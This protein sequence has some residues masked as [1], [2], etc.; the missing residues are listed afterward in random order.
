MMA[1]ENNVD[2][3]LKDLEQG[4]FSFRMVDCINQHIQRQQTEL[5][6]LQLFKTRA[7]IDL[8][9]YE[10][11]TARLERDLRIVNGAI[12][13]L[14]KTNALLEE[15]IAAAKYGVAKF[16]EVAVPKIQQAAVDAQPYAIEAFKY[17]RTAVLKA[18]EAAEP[19][20]KAWWATIEPRLKEFAKSLSSSLPKGQN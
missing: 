7:M 16:G 5:D 20:V 10:Q 15:G 19:H 3:A 4:K 13:R 1:I 9:K 11:E 2:K 6:A 18:A 12:L 8:A 17:T 14:I